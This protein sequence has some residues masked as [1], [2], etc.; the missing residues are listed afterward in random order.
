MALTALSFIEIVSQ[1]PESAIEHLL[2]ALRLSPRDPQRPSVLFEPRDGGERLRASLRRQGVNRRH[3]GDPRGTRSATLYAHLAVNYMGLG[4][5]AKA[6]AALD[7]ATRIA[8][9]QVE[10]SLAGFMFRK[11]GHQ[12]RGTTFLRIAAGLEDPATGGR[13]ALKG[14]TGE[15]ATPHLEERLMLFIPKECAPARQGR[16]A[17]DS[18]HL[19]AGAARF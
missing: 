2:E 14:E 11:R 1:K 17:K 19:R 9:G 8:P 15:M 6:R 13:P 10:R 3:A 16:N 12:Q 7:E 5:I 18:P 4:E